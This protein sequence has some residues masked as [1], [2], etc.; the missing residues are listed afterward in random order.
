MKVMSKITLRQM[1]LNKRRTIVTIIG[2]IISV[3]MFTAVSTLSGSFMNFMQR[4]EIASS[5]NYHAKFIGVSSDDLEMLQQD[6]NTKS[7]YAIHEEGLAQLPEQSGSKHFLNVESISVDGMEAAGVTVTDGRLPQNDQEIVISQNLKNKAGDS[8]KIGDTITLTMGERRAVNVEDSDESGAGVLGSGSAYMGSDET[9]RETGKKTYTVVGFATAFS[10]EPSWVPYYTAITGLN[11]D[12]LYQKT[13]TAYVQVNHVDTTIYDWIDNMAEKTGAEI[14]SAHTGLLMFSGVDNDPQFMATMY[15]L[16]GILCAIIFIG[17]VALIYNAFAISVSERSVN[18]GLLASVGATKRQKMRSVLFEALLILVVAV[19]LGI[20]GGLLGIWGVFEAVNP[21]VRSL[22][23]GDFGGAAIG[24]QVTVSPWAILVA[25][26]LSVLTTLISAWVPAKRASRI[27]PMEA[28]R[29]T[30]DI[31]L[32]ARSVRTS[33]VTRVLFGFEGEIAAKNMKRNKKRYRIAISSFVISLVLFLSASSFT[34]YLT[35][36]SQ[37]AVDEVDYDVIVAPVSNG[38][39]G[40]S[41]HFTSD[42]QQTQLEAAIREIRQ[43]GGVESFASVYEWTQQTKESD[44]HFTQEFRD[45]TGVD[46]DADSPTSITLLFNAVDDETLREYCLRV[47]ADY[48]AMQ[49]TEQPS[50]ILINDMVWQD[51]RDYANYSAYD[52]QKGDMLEYRYYDYLKDDG[53]QESSIRLEAV[54]GEVVTGV[55]GRRYEGNDFINV[56]ISEKV[57]REYCLALDHRAEYFAQH[58]E[59]ANDEDTFVVMIET[60]QIYIAASDPA[61]LTDDIDELNYDPSYRGIY[62]N[63]YDMTSQK[64]MIEQMLFLINTFSYVFIALISA[65]GV[66]NIFNTIS[67]SIILRKREFAMLKSVGMSPRSFNKMLFFESLLYGLKSLLWGLPI[68]F[69]MMGLIYWAL[70]GNFHMA[71]TVPWTQVIIGIA[72]IF[73]IVMI[74]VLYAAR[75]VKGENII[76][77]LRN[78]NL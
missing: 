61:A 43:M 66:A 73:A 2:V 74:T 3:A 65:I 15:T 20:A 22:L 27:S 32:T 6:E 46:K 39:N 4:A 70:E 16:V 45:I 5:G 29:Q 76:D 23:S 67:T 56:V 64:R 77:G 78:T 31:K 50:A 69:A 12:V 1:R 59:E 63:A 62:F 19:P 13:L 51:G 60:P 35:A 58:R 49:D 52:L 38:Y 72:A 68:S 9:F 33:P 71:F 24:L 44:P 25:V 28:I 36:S 21:T 11:P 7:L 75:K 14:A 41:N 30:K 26:V 57:Y 55:G 53:S 18:F 17:S 8:Y 54:T 42:E 48:D 34:H 37:M 47:G 40:Q 10:R